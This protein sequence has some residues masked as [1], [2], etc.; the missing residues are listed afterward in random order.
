MEKQTLMPGAACQSKTVSKQ[1][2][3]STRIAEAM[4]KSVFQQ[5]RQFGRRRDQ[6]LQLVNDANREVREYLSTAGFS[7]SA[8]GRGIGK[9]LVCLRKARGGRDE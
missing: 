7:C 4:G 9:R 6:Q 3:E 5:N 8:M 1:L 2:A